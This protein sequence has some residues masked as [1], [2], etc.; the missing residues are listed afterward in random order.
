MIVIDAP[1][2]VAARVKMK[3]RMPWATDPVSPA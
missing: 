2:I 1:M 3:P